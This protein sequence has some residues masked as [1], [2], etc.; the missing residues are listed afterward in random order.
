MYK[1][2][3]LI[4]LLDLIEVKL[5]QQITLK[6]LAT[7]CQFLY[8]SLVLAPSEDHTLSNTALEYNLILAQISILPCHQSQTIPFRKKL[9]DIEWYMFWLV[10]APRGIHRHLPSTDF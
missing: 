6:F 8:L 9:E 3:A 5:L 10:K 4:L 1:L 2:Q 7:H